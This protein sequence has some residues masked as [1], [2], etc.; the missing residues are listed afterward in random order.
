MIK[1]KLIQ[2]KI[3]NKDHMNSLKKIHEIKIT[4]NDIDNVKKEL[5]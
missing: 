4:F 1:L 3:T 5:K 2:G